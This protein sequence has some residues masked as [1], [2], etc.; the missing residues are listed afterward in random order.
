[1]AE[2]PAQPTA[3]LRLRA[4]PV[5]LPLLAALLL[6]VLLLAAQLLAAAPAVPVR[7][8]PAVQLA[9]VLL[10]GP[11]RLVRVV[12]RARRPHRTPSSS[13]RRRAR[14]PSSATVT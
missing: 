5:R 8:R 7:T 10:L 11:L 13:L 3:A 2:R 4:A 12:A 1:M 9:A 14:V 6:A